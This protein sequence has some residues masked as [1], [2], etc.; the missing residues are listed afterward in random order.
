MTPTHRLTRHFL[1]G[2]LSADGGVGN[3]TPA[4]IAVAALVS[5]G[6]FVTVLFAAKYVMAPW[7]LPAESALGGLF[8]RLLFHCAAFVLLTL[9]ALVHWD[10]LALDGRDAAI[11]GVLPLSRGQIVRAKWTATAAFGA[12]AAVLVTTLPSLIYPIVSIGRLDATWSLLIWLALCQW[13]IGVLAG[14]T[15]FV[16]VIALRELAW[17]LLGPRLFMRISA[18]MQGVLIVMSVIALFLLPSWTMQQVTPPSI[19]HAGS[20]RVSADATRAL[21]VAPSSVALWLPPVMWTGAFETVAGHQVAHLTPAPD[22]PQA[23]KVRNR[24]YLHQY[25]SSHGALDGSLR[26]AGATFGGLAALAMLAAVWN[27]RGRAAGGALL[28]TRRSWVVTMIDR[29]ARAVPRPETRAGFGFS[30]RTLMRSQPHRLLLAVGL[31][32]G[33]AAGTVGLVDDPPRHSTLGDASITL[34][35]VQ[36]LLV[37]C[38]AGGV[39]AALRRGGDA[40]AAWIY[41]LTWT[42]ARTAYD[43]GVVMAATAV[44]CL[45][46][47][48]LLPLY[49]QVFG[50]LE[51]LLHVV[52]GTLL[53]LVLMETLVLR[54]ATLPLVEDAPTSDVGKA[55]PMLALPAAVIGAAIVAAV[56]RRAPAVAVGTLITLWLVLHL[57]RTLRPAPVGALSDVDAHDSAI[58]LGLYR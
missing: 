6:L 2:Y 35:S 52:I 55:M 17:A 3:D 18:A 58:E 7:P 4:A 40:R 29:A 37:A 57:M 48:M 41:P 45:P 24:Q 28:P 53:A 11:L 8:D 49:V 42:G 47:L 39:R 1:R 5:P 31:A 56:E 16:T 26:R 12:G 34:L 14:A 22:Y 10:R 51:A 13:V 30:W 19:R 46:L 50:V 36:S 15:G 33:L 44:T 9:V 23:I 25:W 27:G 20:H 21:P 38:I 43:S 32:G 54:H